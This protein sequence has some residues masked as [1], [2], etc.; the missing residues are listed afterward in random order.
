MPW[1]REEEIRIKFVMQPP[2]INAF[3]VSNHTEC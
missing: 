2:V 1:V 3:S